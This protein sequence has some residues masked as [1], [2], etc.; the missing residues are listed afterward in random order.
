MVH[1]KAELNFDLGML[2][3]AILVTHIQ[4]AS[5]IEAVSVVV[6]IA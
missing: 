5:L 3:Y 1:L 4:H 2:R 6:N